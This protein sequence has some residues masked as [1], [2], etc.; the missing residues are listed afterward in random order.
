MECTNAKWFLDSY[1]PLLVFKLEVSSPIVRIPFF[2]G[3][4]LNLQVSKQTVGF[5]GLRL[6]F[7][8][9]DIRTVFLLSLRLAWKKFSL[10]LAAQELQEEKM[11]GYNHLFAAGGSDLVSGEQ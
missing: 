5:C 1:T 10:E 3:G 4:Y 2:L 7:F 11:L 9:V 6:A 8:L